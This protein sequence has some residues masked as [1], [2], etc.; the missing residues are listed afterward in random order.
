MISNTMPAK[1]LKKS[2]NDSL[3]KRTEYM[4]VPIRVEYEITET[5][6]GLKPIFLELAQWGTDLE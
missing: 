6:A 3:V 4:E 1:S 5:A 2:E